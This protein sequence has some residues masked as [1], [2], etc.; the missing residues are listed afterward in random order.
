VDLATVFVTSIFFTSLMDSPMSAITEFLRII[1]NPKKYE[2]VFK[3][4]HDVLRKRPELAE[5]VKQEL[6]KRG[7]KV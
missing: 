2:Q 1:K 7:V 6:K 5:Q 3:P 4:M